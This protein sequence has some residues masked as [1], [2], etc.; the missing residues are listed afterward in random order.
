M[1]PDMHKNGEEYLLERG[2]TIIIKTLPM[3]EDSGHLFGFDSNHSSH[4][5]GFDSNDPSHVQNY[6]SELKLYVT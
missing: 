4:V 6:T 3:F 1:L 5:F 2:P